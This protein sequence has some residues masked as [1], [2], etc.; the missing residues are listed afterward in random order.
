MEWGLRIK[1]VGMKI[2][3]SNKA[4]ELRLGTKEVRMRAKNME[5]G[6]K[7]KEGMLE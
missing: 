4:W 5:Q 7:T 1:E 6:L 3:K 2:D